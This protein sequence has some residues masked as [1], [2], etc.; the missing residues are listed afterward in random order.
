MKQLILIISITLVT[1]LLH[2]QQKELQVNKNTFLHLKQAYEVSNEAK[3]TQ[4]F[5]SNA[6]QRRMFEN[7]L[8]GMISLTPQSF[9][10]KTAAIC[11]CKLKEGQLKRN[12]VT[13]ITNFLSSLRSN[14]QTTLLKN[15]KELTSV[16]D[17]SP[18]MLAIIKTLNEGEQPTTQAGGRGFWRAAGAIIGGLIGGAISGGGTLGAGAAPGAA[19]GALAGKEIADEL[20]DQYYGVSSNSGSNVMARPDGGDCSSPVMSCPLF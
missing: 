20:Y 1:G 14:N 4:R 3:L 19:I 10:S 8:L 9:N 5:I 18:L 16:K 6:E 12:E 2:A 7:D 15:Y 13:V 17:A 11:N